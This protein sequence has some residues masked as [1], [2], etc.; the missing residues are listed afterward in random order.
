MENFIENDEPVAYDS[1]DD[2]IKGIEFALENVET[3]QRTIACLEAAR[4]SSTLDSKDTI[5]SLSLASITRES[6]ASIYGVQGYV[7][8]SVC[9]E[10][11][12]H[13]LIFAIEEE[14]EK[15][16]NLLERIIDSIVKAWRWLV[17][18]VTSIFKKDSGDSGSSSNKAEKNVEESS[19]KIKKI[20]KLVADGKA[21]TFSD[22]FTEKYSKAF[23]HIGT[24]VTLSQ[25]K[26]DVAEHAV[27]AEHIVRAL[28]QL[29]TKTDQM[30]TLAESFNKDSDT[31]ET[32]KKIDDF[33]VQISEQLLP[34]FPKA[35][36]QSKHMSYIDKTVEFHLDKAKLIGPFMDAKG[37]GICIFGINRVG[38][39]AVGYEKWKATDSGTSKLQ[40]PTNANELLDY[41]KAVESASKTIAEAE[42]KLA[43]ETVTHIKSTASTVDGLLKDLKKASSSKEL[44]TELTRFIKLSGAMGSSAAKLSLTM[45]QVSETSAAIMQA[46]INDCLGEAKKDASNE[47]KKAKEETKAEEKPAAT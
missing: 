10:S 46:V 38:S 31:A 27:Y 7:A 11:A 18:K 40:N 3:L 23:L 44:N 5:R 42:K 1:E 9:L 47:T 4:H 33:I 12:S 20:E 2:A 15:S 32:K 29:L 28:D 26:S 21:I 35:F 17:D 45:K 6:I 16:K 25:L 41:A 37:P 13:N 19:E 22:A 30:K 43:S 34:E 14:S 8:S 24:S 36:E 39:P